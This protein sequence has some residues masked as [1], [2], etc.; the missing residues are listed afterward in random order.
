M[1]S[2]RLFLD[3]VY[4]QAIL[5]RA[6]QH[7]ARAVA[8]YPRVK[9]AREVWVTEAVLLEVGAA[10]SALDRMAAARFL[11]SLYLTPNVHV[12]PIEAILFQRGLDLYEMRPDKTWSLTDCLSF[13]VMKD[14]TLYLAVTA[15]EHFQQAGYHALM[16]EGL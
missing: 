1:S 4:I 11:R 7:H 15:D 13:V 10:L 16:R 2:E 9:A 5:N 12:V 14:Q 8:L 3:T 6:D